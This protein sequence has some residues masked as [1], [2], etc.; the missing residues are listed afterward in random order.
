MNAETISVR[1]PRRFYGI[2]EAQFCLTCCSGKEKRELYSERGRSFVL[3]SFHTRCQDLLFCVWGNDLFVLSATVGR[4][5]R[6]FIRPK[7][8]HKGVSLNQFNL[9]AR[10]KG[11]LGVSHGGCFIISSFIKAL[12]RCLLFTARLWARRLSLSLSRDGT[13]TSEHRM[14]HGR[15]QETK[16]QKEGFSRH[17]SR[18]ED[19]YTRHI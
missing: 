16:E 6:G 5:I 3:F 2:V 13:K 7:L 9:R 8:K 18:D 12:L 19:S 10:P 11:A 15:N 1:I 14:K 4:H 17:T